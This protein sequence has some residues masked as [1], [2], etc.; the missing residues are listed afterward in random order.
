MSTE[1]KLD[2][3]FFVCTNTRDSGKESCSQ[4]NSANLRNKLKEAC[5]NE[6]AFKNHSIRINAA[7]CLGRCAEGIV[8]VSYPEQKW[9]TNLT[10][11]DSENLL[12]EI[13]NLLHDKTT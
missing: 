6:P 10:E 1:K 11:K 5:K 12:T 4:K 8:A 3:H 2:L 9:F 7:G 13:K